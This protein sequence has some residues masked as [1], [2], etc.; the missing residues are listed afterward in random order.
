MYA[1]GTRAIAYASYTIDRDLLQ[2]LL[3]AI[4]KYAAQK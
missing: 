4:I 1:G 3:W 2:V